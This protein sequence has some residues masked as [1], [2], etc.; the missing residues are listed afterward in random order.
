MLEDIRNHDPAPTPEE[1]ELM[2]TNLL[3]LVFRAAAL[4]AIA[5]SVGISATL[6]IDHAQKAPAVAVTTPG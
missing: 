5:L 2:S 1:S 4:A 6:V 3:S